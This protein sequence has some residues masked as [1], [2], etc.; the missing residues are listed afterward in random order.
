MLVDM[1]EH[2]KATDHIPD[3]DQRE[4]GIIERVLEGNQHAFREIVELYAPR[5]LAFCRARL[6]SEEEAQDAAQEVFIR[7]YKSLSTFRRGENFASWLFAIA[8]NNVRTHF[9]IRALRQKNEAI[10]QQWHTENQMF[11]P[12]EDAELAL[13]KIAL[14]NA[15]Q[16]LSEDLR[17][18]VA[19]YYFAELSVRETAQVLGVSEEAVKSRLFRARHQLREIVQRKEQRD[20]SKRGITL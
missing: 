16:S 17:K 15:V 1:P 18:P 20:P 3:F 10:I 5:V 2:T 19:L 7:A 11:D 9:R 6:R 12:E 14:R 8:A 13:Q 4:D